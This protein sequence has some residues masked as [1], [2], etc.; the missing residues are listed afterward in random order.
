MSSATRPISTCLA[1]GLALSLANQATAQVPGSLFTMAPVVGFAN[2][3]AVVPMSSLNPSPLDNASSLVGN[4]TSAAGGGVLVVGDFKTPLGGNFYRLDLRLT[5]QTGHSVIPLGYQF[6]GSATTHW[7]IVVGHDVNGYPIEVDGSEALFVSSMDFTT[8]DMA[9]NVMA[10]PTSILA[11]ANLYDPDYGG[12]W[13]GNLNFSAPQSLLTGGV[14][15][16]K[17]SIE[18]RVGQP[19]DFQTWFNSG[20]APAPWAST[21]YL[22]LA[23]AAVIGQPMRI[24]A[25]NVPHPTLGLWLMIGDTNFNQ[26]SL[27]LIGGDPNCMSWISSISAAPFMPVDTSG[28]ADNQVTFTLPNNPALVGAEFGLQPLG[29]FGQPQWPSNGFYAGSYSQVTIGG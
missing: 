14:S 1:F 19:N 29:I 11:T 9:G 8:Y 21:P 18:Y 6:N 7:G 10:G 15:Q 5:G 12:G 28:V 3:T 13:D 17:I 27:G 2:G 25:N 24:E 4:A 16:V 20:C 22:E 26:V 23:S